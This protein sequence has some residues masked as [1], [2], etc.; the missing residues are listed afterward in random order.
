MSKK[1]FMGAKNRLQLS[2]LSHGVEKRVEG[3]KDGKSSNKKMAN[4]TFFAIFPSRFPCSSGNPLANQ[5]RPIMQTLG[6]IRI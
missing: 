5:D 4:M 6:P 1:E 2:W 3:W